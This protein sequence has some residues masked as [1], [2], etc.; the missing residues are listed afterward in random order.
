LTTPTD[1]QFDISKAVSELKALRPA[2]KEVLGFYEELC[3]AQEDSKKRVR[4]SPPE[5][6]E[7]LLATKRKEGFPLISPSEFC[8]DVQASRDLLTVFLRLAEDSNERLAESAKKI[9]DAVNDGVFEAHELFGSILS[10]ANDDLENL[11]NEI[12]MD[13]KILALIAYHCVRPSVCVHSEQLAATY[14]DK[15]DAWEKGYC[16]VCGS[17]PALSMLQEDGGQRVLVCVLCA[18]EWPAD[19][20]YCPFCENRDSKSLAYFFSEAEKDCRVDTCEKCGT[21]I[22]TLDV[23]EMNRPVYPLIEQIA[24]L[25]LDMMAMERGLK[26]GIPLWLQHG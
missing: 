10:E 26:S 7:D 2:Y 19:R 23:R 24:S 21:Y 12:G 11:S 15:K 8:V 13:K 9:H 25:H 3:L 20:I 16:P 6:G 5:I 4:L 1:T 17:P 18:H 22:K 14:L